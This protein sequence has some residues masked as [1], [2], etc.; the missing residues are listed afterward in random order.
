MPE[1][2]RFVNSTPKEV[3]QA[4]VDAGLDDASKLQSLNLN[5]DAL[6]EWLKCHPEFAGPMV[7]PLLDLGA[8][9]DFREIVSIAHEAENVVGIL[10][11]SGAEP[12]FI[13][14]DS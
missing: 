14:T 13:P 5:P 8:A 9:Q 11:L 3:Y 7:S 2:E 10:N 1:F 6:F 12:E 4:A